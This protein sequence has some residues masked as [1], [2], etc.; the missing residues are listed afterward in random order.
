MKIK[1]HVKKTFETTDAY[2]EIDSIEKRLRE[3]S[4]LVVLDEGAFMG[5]L[6]SSDIIESKHNLVIDCLHDNPRIDCE[7]DIEL[8]LKVMNDSHNFVLPVFDGDVFIGIV[9]QASITDFLFEYHN[10]LKRAISERTAELKKAHDELKQQV[11]T[12]TS[13]LLKSTQ[14]LQNRQEELLGH[15]LELEKVNKELLDTNNAVSVLAKNI[16]KNRE[17]AEKK[18][19]LSINSNI[20]PI[21]ENLK[22]YKTLKD[23]W[24]ELDVLVAYLH[25]ISTSLLNSTDII[26]R[27]SSAEM[28]IAAMIKNGLTSKEITEK[29]HLSID[30]VKT[31][32]RNIRKKLNIHKSNINLTNYLRQKWG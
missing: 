22:N 30:T 21:I 8:V 27:L 4:F 12:R 2:A 25:D 19:A 17:E 7:Q 18:I 24:A 31:H 6:T 14:E 5:I 11:E 26:I 1:H 16:D 29:L 9:L 23:H 20:M 13:E 10:E 28:R 32:R 15:K 3:N